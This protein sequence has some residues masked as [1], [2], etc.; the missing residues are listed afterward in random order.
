M[1]TGQDE[2]R[3][4]RLATVTV[5]AASVVVAIW[6]VLRPSRAGNS[7]TGRPVSVEPVQ[8]SLTPDERARVQRVIAA[9]R[10]TLPDQVVA[11]AQRDAGRTSTRGSG[12]LFSPISPVGTAVRA[13]RPQF[14]WSDAGAD[15]Y[16][17]TVFDE[18]R[19]EVERSARV[20]GTSWTASR[21]LPRGGTYRWQVTAHRGDRNETEPQPPRPDAKFI[22]LDAAAV[23]Q[24]EAAEARLAREPLPL[25]ILLAEAGL[26]SEARV[27]LTRAVKV[28]DTAAAA[29]RLLES[30]DPK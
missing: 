29:R 9:G 6:I 3:W 25:G 21:D 16:T 28:P 4:K 24:I 12:P 20:G 7:A 1:S 10:I 19:N 8:S 11:L 17:V 2:N 18:S 22:V 5:V 26:I 27:D 14:T 13:S 30:L 23:A 15:A